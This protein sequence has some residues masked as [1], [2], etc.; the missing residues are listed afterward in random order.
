VCVCG[1]SINEDVFVVIMGFFSSQPSP[2]LT[3]FSDFQI[4][5]QCEDKGWTALMV[6]AWLGY[7][8]WVSRLLRTGA[9][10][11]FVSKNGFVLGNQSVIAIRSSDCKYRDLSLYLWCS[12]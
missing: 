4:D 2:L 12:G 10:A 3:E 7:E 8:R 9:N 11:N 5:E 1:G 6:A